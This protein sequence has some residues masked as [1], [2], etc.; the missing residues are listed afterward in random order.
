MHVIKHPRRVYLEEC[1][2][3]TPVPTKKKQPVPAFLFLT[4]R[5]QVLN[6]CAV[7][8]AVDVDLML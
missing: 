7:L 8:L 3:H 5:Y 2:E 6:R 4:T 1:V